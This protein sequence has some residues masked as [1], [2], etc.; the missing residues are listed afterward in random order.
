MDQVFSDPYL[1]VAVRHGDVRAYETLRRRHGGAARLL[2][3]QL[4]RS[5]AEVDDLVSEAFAR[6]LETV[7]AGCGPEAAFRPYLLTEV[8]QLATAASAEDVPGLD[9]KLAAR[10]FAC[11]PERWQMVLWHTAVEGESS[12]EVAPLLGLTPNGVSALVHRAYEGLRQ[13]YVHVHL[14][15]V[16][17]D[18]CCDVAALLGTR[19]W[20][21]LPREEAAHLDECRRC[22]TFAFEVADVDSGMRGAVVPQVLGAGTAGYLAAVP[23]K[24]ASVEAPAPTR[25]RRRS[26]WRTR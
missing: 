26:W 21:G 16:T 3:R 5:Q 22:R 23:K 19:A 11:L 2:A 24:A 12:A 20:G 18:E 14:D 6:V 1:I 8:R 15:D 17:E 7:R 10:A 25:R 4:S 13:A 9:R